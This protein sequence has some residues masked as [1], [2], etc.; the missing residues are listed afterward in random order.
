ME[1]SKNNKKGGRPLK[2]SVK[3]IIAAISDTGGIKTEI[4][5]RIG[6]DR[7]TLNLYI[8]K[9]PKVKE[10][11]EEEEEKVLDMAEGALFSLIQNGDTSA[12]FYFLNNRGK[13]RGYAPPQKAGVDTADGQISKERTGV[14]VTPGLLTEEAWENAANKTGKK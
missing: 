9:F 4:C 1:N 5:K 12:I 6:C 8:A 11:Y 13:R 7:R 3:N 2:Y 10:A 14:L